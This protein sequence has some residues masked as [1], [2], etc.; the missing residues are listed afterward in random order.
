MSTALRSAYQPVSNLKCIPTA[1][2]N[3]TFQP[4]LMLG[5][6]NFLLYFFQEFKT[7]G[8]SNIDTSKV[9]GALETKYKWAEYGLTFTEKWTTENTLGTEVCVED[10]V[11]RKLLIILQVTKF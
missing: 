8:L 5:W 3:E 2:N 4:M 9:T 11:N 7:S 1:Q 6:I 10:Q